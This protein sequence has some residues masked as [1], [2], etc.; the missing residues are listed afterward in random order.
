MLTKVNWFVACI[1]LRVVGAVLVVF[2]RRWRKIWADPCIPLLGPGGDT[3]A[4]GG[5]GGRQHFDDGT[6]TLVL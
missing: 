1:A 3:L 5:L 4:C 6:D 2:L